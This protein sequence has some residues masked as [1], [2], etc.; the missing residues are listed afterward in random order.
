MEWSAPSRASSVQKDSMD[1]VREPTF[2]LRTGRVGEKRSRS[3][4]EGPAKKRRHCGFCTAADHNVRACPVK[5]RLGTHITAL[6]TPTTVGMIPEWTDAVTDQVNVTQIPLHIG[7]LQIIGVLARNKDE[8]K[9]A[10][11]VDTTRFV[12]NM[13]AESMPAGTQAIASPDV[14]GVQITWGNIKSFSRD[15]TA[16]NRHVFLSHSGSE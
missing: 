16:K 10:C 2:A 4:G 3:A 6:P 8:C 9:L 7:V 11:A 5:R 14:A 15:F 13:F 12:V 1:E